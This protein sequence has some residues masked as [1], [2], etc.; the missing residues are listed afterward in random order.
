MARKAKEI[1][2]KTEDKKTVEPINHEAQPVENG[3]S[4]NFDQY[5]ARH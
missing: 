4:E 5:R 2:P 3:A 1:T